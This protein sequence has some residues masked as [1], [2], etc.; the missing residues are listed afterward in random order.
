MGAPRRAAY[1]WVVIAGLSA[2]FFA[3]LYYDL[4]WRWRGRFNA[5]GRYFDEDA[6]VVYRQQNEAL[7]IPLAIC[8]LWLIAALWFA[9]KRQ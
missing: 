3:W 6:V 9:F 2:A 5:E 8:G 1:V 4:Y 7:V